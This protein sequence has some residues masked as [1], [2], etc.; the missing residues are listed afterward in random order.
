MTDIASYPKMNNDLEQCVKSCATRAALTVTH[1]GSPLSLCLLIRAPSSDVVMSI[2]HRSEDAA[3]LELRRFGAVTHRSPCNGVSTTPHVRHAMLEA[4]LTSAHGSL[5]G[6][7]VNIIPGD[8]AHGGGA[9][10]GGR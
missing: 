4:R 5:T 3:T 1:T 7:D 8:V 2:A 9:R 6:G 10:G